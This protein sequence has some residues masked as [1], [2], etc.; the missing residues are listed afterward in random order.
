MNISSVKKGRRD[1]SSSNSKKMYDVLSPLIKHFKEEYKLSKGDLVNIYEGV[2][3][4][5]VPLSIFSGKLSPLEALVKYLKENLGLR[6]HQIASELNRD[7]RSIWG[8]YRNIRSKGGFSFDLKK[9]ELFIP[10]SIFKDR[11]LS[12][13]ENFIT[14]LKEEYN[15]PIKEISFLINKKLS[16]VWTAHNRAKKKR[17]IKEG[18]SNV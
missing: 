18:A 14:Y 16:T 5:K 15:I 2:E 1:S 10:V 8:T 3:K 12:I 7:D 9:N 11:S 13:L 17:K 6:Y 4:I